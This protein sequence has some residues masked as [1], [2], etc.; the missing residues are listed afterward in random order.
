MC[1]NQLHSF[2][3]NGIF[4]A[5]VGQKAGLFHKWGRVHYLLSCNTVLV[6]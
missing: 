3:V 1:V 4:K 6:N 2:Y 5:V